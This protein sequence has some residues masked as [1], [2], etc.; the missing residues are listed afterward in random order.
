MNKGQLII[1]YV[2]SVGEVHNLK[3]KVQEL[4][5]K[6]KSF[7]QQLLLYDVVSSEKINLTRKEL[8]EVIKEAYRNGYSKYEMV[9]AGLE[10]YDADGYARWSMRS[11][12]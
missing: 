1:K 7:E 4:E 2:K 10:T 11:I 3:I 8:R 9:E 5:N 6:L 12:K